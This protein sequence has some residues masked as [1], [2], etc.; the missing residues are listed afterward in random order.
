MN[1]KVISITALALLSSLGAYASIP[2]S[3]APFQ[4]QVPNLKAGIEVYIEGFYARPSNSDLDYGTVGTVNY[5]NFGFPPTSNLDVLTVDPTLQAGFTVG[6]GYIFPNS[7]NDIQLSWTSYNHG[8][9]ESYFTVPGQTLSSGTT[10]TETNYLNSTYYVVVSSGDIDEVLFREINEQ[11]L[12]ASS[13]VDTKLNVIDLD[14]GQ[15]VDVG[16]RLQT[17][18]FAGVRGA[19]LEQITENLYHNMQNDYITEGFDFVSSW[20]YKDDLITTYDSTYKGVGPRLGVSSDYNIWNCFGIHGQFATALLVGKLKE[21]TSNWQR[22]NVISNVTQQPI[23]SNWP[24][25]SNTFL[26]NE[27]WRVVPSFDAKLGLNYSF[28]FR[29]RSALTFEAGYQVSEFINAVDKIEAG[30]GTRVTS[31]MGFDGPY[32]SLNFAV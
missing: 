30:T 8:Y 10:F 32:A 15:Y 25:I 12:N 23:N 1:K 29:N 11:F 31:D 28:I 9:A 22:L 13:S 27:T 24:V 21:E 5:N 20:H 4:L 14:V 7:G 2:T 19:K 18:F 6:I 16:T 26:S 17:R 3:A